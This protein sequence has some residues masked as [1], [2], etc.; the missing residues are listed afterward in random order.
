MILLIAKINSNSAF[1]IFFLSLFESTICMKV[2][3]TLIVHTLSSLF[4]F[5]AKKTS[6]LILIPILNVFKFQ[7]LIIGYIDHLD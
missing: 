4:C 3:R 1:G 7:F 6:M 5:F 2:C